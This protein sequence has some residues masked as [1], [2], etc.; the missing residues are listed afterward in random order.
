MANVH[1]SVLSCPKPAKALLNAVV[2]ACP[3]FWL[4]A[5]VAVGTFFSQVQA[6]EK[7]STEHF[8][9]SRRCIFLSKGFWEGVPKI[10]NFGAFC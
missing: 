5:L 7:E 1:E 10:V 4:R 2:D 8:D 6:H 3:L 9:Q